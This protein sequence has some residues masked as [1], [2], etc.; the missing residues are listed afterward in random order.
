MDELISLEDVELKQIFD[1]SSDQTNRVKCLIEKEYELA[2]TRE[3]S[4]LFVLRDEAFGI[5]WKKRLEKLDFIS[6]EMLDAL[7]HSHEFPTAKSIIGDAIIKG[8]FTVDNCVQVTQSCEDGEWVV[9]QAKAFIVTQSILDKLPN[10]SKEFLGEIDTLLE[11]NAVWAINKL[12]HQLNKSTLLLLQDKVL[13]STS[14]S[15]RDRN[16]IGQA[17][18]KKT[19]SI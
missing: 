16:I 1:L 18:R 10:I 13:N 5:Y 3:P 8:K 9:K 12:L 15:K 14:L 11:L 2:E 6:K 4:A 7:L 17:I 19:K